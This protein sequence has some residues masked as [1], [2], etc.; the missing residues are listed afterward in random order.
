MVC[1]KLDVARTFCFGEN[2]VNLGCKFSAKYAFTF[3]SLKYLTSQNAPTSIHWYYWVIRIH[4]GDF[5]RL[6]STHIS[7]CVRY[8]HRPCFTV[9]FAALQVSGGILIAYLLYVQ[10]LRL[11]TIFQNNFLASFHLKPFLLR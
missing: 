5:G 10:V 9:L 11:P 6:L 7:V 8:I 2:M 1:S 4:S 3:V